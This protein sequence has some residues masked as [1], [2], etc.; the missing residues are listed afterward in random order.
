MS[1]MIN[2][3]KAKAIY[4]EHVNNI[5]DLGDMPCSFGMQIKEGKLMRS[6]NLSLA[7]QKDIAFLREKLS[8]IIDLRTEPE[9]MESPNPFIEGV[10]ES[11]IPILEDIQV[12][13]SKDQDSNQAAISMELE[14]PD[15]ALELMKSAYRE[16]VASEYCRRQYARFLRS[17]LTER[18]GAILWHCTAGKDRTG[19]CAALLETILG[20]SEEN[21]LEDYTSS[22]LYLKGEIEQYKQALRS[23]KG[24]LSEAESTSVE[25]IYGVEEGYLLT[26]IGEA[27]ERYGSLHGFI[28]EG[29]GITKE[30]EETLRSLY[31]EKA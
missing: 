26:F 24:S 19:T 17:L 31:L 18:N 1:G 6:G 27:E 11:W 14:E 20:V 22:R 15:M 21:I 8:L 25:Y 30:E 16:F 23:Q 13:I 3:E 28:R 2:G 7:T 9:R 10:E 29:L 5:R 4:L 12:G